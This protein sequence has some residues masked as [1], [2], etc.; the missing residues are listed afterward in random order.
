MKEGDLMLRAMLDP[1]RHHGERKL[2]PTWEEPFHITKISKAG[3]CWL[4]HLDGTLLPRPWNQ[5]HL[6]RYYA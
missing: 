2:V 5:V 1:N 6:K 3:V 4:A